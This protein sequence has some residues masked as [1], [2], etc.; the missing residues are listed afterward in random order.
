MRGNDGYPL[1]TNW[2]KAPELEL[3]VW[4][5]LVQ[6]FWLPEKIA[7][8]NDLPS[9]RNMTEDEKSVTMKVFAGLTLLDT[10]QGS[11]G[12]ISLIPDAGNPFEEA[13]LQ[14][15]VFMEA[16]TDEHQLLTDKGW[17]RISE[18][19]ESMLVAQYD[20]EGGE[21]TFATPTLVPSHYA[22]Y[23]YRIAN[24]NGTFMQHVS[25]G[26]RLVWVNPV[27]EHVVATAEELY[28]SV[29][30]GKLG[31]KNFICA[32]TTATG[33][34]D[35]MTVVDKLRV[36]I[37]AD[38]SYDRSL[39][40]TGDY[41]RSGS[42]TGVVPVRFAFSKERKAAR[43]RHLADEAGWELREYEWKGREFQ[44][45]LM[46][47]VEALQDPDRNKKFSNWYSPADINTLWAQEFVEELGYWDAH[48]DKR[49]G[50]TVYNSVDKDNADFV[51]AVGTL[52]GYRSHASLR[53]D[54]RSDTFRNVH[55][56]TINSKHTYRNGQ[57]LTI[58]RE[59]GQQVYCV[60]VPTTFL[61]TRNGR[62]VSITGNCVHA[63]S[64]SSIFSTLAST[65][66]IE[67]AF[68]W[69][70]EDVPTQ[71]KSRTIT[72]IYDGDDPDKRKIASVFLESALFFSGFYWPIYLASRGKLTNTND[73]IMLI[74]R[75]ESIHGY[76]IGQ[77]YQRNIAA[78]SPERQEEL[79]AFT[80]D[81]LLDLYESEAAYAETL[82]DPLGLTE[83]VKN[84]VRYNFN[85]AL[86]N[87]GYDVVFGE[88]DTHISASVESAL[89]PDGGSNHDFF[90]GAG[91][92]YQ[93]AKVEAIDDWD[94]IW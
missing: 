54:D 38:G 15:I 91:S 34:S 68:R 79:K 23:T 46:V 92:T 39:N 83:D 55:I 45:H 5:K 40:N 73:I 49:Y 16:L 84:F 28:A 31:N 41:K 88:D 63:K 77:W 30:S 10:L 48:Y 64:Y 21:V 85:K 35:G 2:N 11:V 67:D 62:S 29:P 74:L 60:Q 43:L 19:D 65:E 20:S 8:S 71:F 9:W 12:M 59:A 26:H 14:N 75:D 17:V 52:A 80:L 72:D 27:G 4:N 94:S 66:Q 22:E 57:S 58:T 18:V 6:N 86:Q 69:A 93:E 25:P 42:I 33:V 51:L 36:A 32:G 81:L 56:V 82:Y 87:L 76:I 89:S 1:P 61:V 37:Q 50:T 78:Q 47:P 70:S 90:S 7:L 3:S 24:N 53:E 44:S 13:I